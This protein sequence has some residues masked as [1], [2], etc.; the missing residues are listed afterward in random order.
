[1]KL[2]ALIATAAF[3]V[4]PSARAQQK[5]SARPD[6]TPLDGYVERVMKE[7][8]VPGV[9][10]AVVRNDSVIL[11]KGYGV[12]AI[13]GA[14]PVDANTVFAIG[15]ASKAF[16]SAL[17]GM[18]VDAGKMSW[19]DPVARYLPGFQLH[20]SYASRSLT[21]RDAMSHRSGLS[22]GDLTWY[23]GKYTREEVL[24]RVRYLEPS[25][26]FRSQ[27]GYQNVMFL[28]A[29]EAVARALQSDWDALIRDRIFTPL[30]MAR[31]NTSVRANQGLS[32]VSSP[33]NELRDTVRVIPWKNIDNIAPAGSINS[34]VTDM[35]QWLRLQLAQGKINGK[36]LI[37]AP[38]IEEM[39]TPNTHIRLQGPTGGY[40]APGANVSSYGLG[41]FVQDFKGQLAIHHGGNI[42]GFSAVV[43]M[44]PRKNTGV[45]VLTNM[46]GTPA[47]N[48]LFP[49][50]F[51]LLLG[52]TPQDWSASYQKML[53]GAR[54]AASAAEAAA[55]KSR[56]AGTKPTHGLDAYAGTWTDSLYGDVEVL[57]RDGGL[58]IEYGSM[59]GA[60]EHWHYD[61]FR[62]EL[63]N[64]AG[65]SLVTFSLD[66][67]GKVAQLKAQLFPDR[68]FT[69]RPSVNKAGPTV[70]LATE[71]LQRFVGTY[72]PQGMPVEFDVSVVGDLLKFTVPGQPSYTLQPVTAKRF[73]LTLPTASLPDGFYLEFTEG[74][75]DITGATLE[76][77]APQPTMKLE[78]V[79]K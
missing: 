6:L 17:V 70:A 10:I 79:R 57:Q 35:A 21:L 69:R 39:W 76:Q 28:A 24:Q 74:G 60:M 51:E 18:A 15:S 41:W 5:V 52:E 7:W 65:R 44:L 78:K 19:D 23:S 64:G 56:V 20:D 32:N 45:V 14:E 29:G 4:A 55:E 2:Y 22:R 58:R 49:Y 72:K 47:P 31:S 40:L 38:V 11:A 62:A 59:V 46:N 68:T 54:Q 73:R 27:F 37:T 63:D 53:S 36:Q 26:S 75:S 13:G 48:I 43:A 9:A 66:E 8:K 30:S 34:S 25:W 33:H 71:Q 12:R 16:T 77:P 42:D 67:N 3:V 1:M 50:V 61:T